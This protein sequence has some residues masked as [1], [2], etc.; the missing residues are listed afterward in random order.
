MRRDNRRL[1]RPV[2]LWAG[3]VQREIKRQCESPLV[4]GRATVFANSDRHAVQ[5]CSLDRSRRGS[6]CEWLAPLRSI[7][8]N[9]V[10]LAPGEIVAARKARWCELHENL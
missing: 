8:S 4:P 3:V 5:K 7:F 10:E 6:D 9:C 2:A 1:Q